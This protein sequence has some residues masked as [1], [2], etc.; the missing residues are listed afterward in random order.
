MGFSLVGIH[1]A[2]NYIEIITSSAFAASLEALC[3]GLRGMVMA[4]A[5]LALVVGALLLQL[6]VREFIAPQ[7]PPEPVMPLKTFNLPTKPCVSLWG[8]PYLPSPAQLQQAIIVRPKT[9]R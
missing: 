3:L 5:A 9:R 8:N 7:G 2:L 1:A 6:G 4:F